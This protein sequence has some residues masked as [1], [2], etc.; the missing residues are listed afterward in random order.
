M[1]LVEIDARAAWFDLTADCSRDSAP[2][3]FD[4]GEIFGDRA[5]RAVLLNELADNVVHWLKYV[6]VNADVPVAVGHDVMAGA[7]FCFRG[8][9]QLVLFTLRGDVIDLD[10]AIVL[11]APLITK[12][13]ERIIGPGNPVVPHAERERTRRVNSF[14][15]RRRNSGGGAE[16]RRFHNL[17]ACRTCLGEQTG[18]GHRFPPRGLK[19]TAVIIGLLA[20]SKHTLVADNGLVPRTRSS[21]E[22]AEPSARTSGSKAAL[23]G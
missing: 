9:R 4:L 12:L 22:F 10:F 1:L 13:G 15:I 19:G 7:G 8:R 23:Q 6:L 21:H 17:A 18:L 20:W 5:D 11:G 16:R 2:G 3:A 14:D